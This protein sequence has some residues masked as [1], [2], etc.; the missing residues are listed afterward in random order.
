MIMVTRWVKEMLMVHDL[1]VAVTWFDG[2]LPGVLWT[3]SLEREEDK[4][5]SRLY[6][7]LMAFCYLLCDPG[8]FRGA[9]LGPTDSIAHRDPRRFL[10]GALHFAGMCD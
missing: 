8:H 9:L 4:W 5:G 7:Q 2:F 3:S 10:F 1:L 6:G